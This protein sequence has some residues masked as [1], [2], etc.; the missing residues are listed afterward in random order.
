M[1][2]IKY[3]IIIYM[4]YPLMYRCRDLLFGG[5]SQDKS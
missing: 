3:E 4:Y 5:A 1:L 2:S